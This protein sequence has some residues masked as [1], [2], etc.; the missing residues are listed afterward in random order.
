[1]RYTTQMSELRLDGEWDST[2]QYGDGLS[3]NHVMVFE[4]DS[5]IGQSLPQEDGSEINMALRHNPETN[6]L[7]GF[8]REETSPTG[9]YKGKVFEG[10]VHFILNKEITRAEGKWTGHNSD[11]TAVNTGI[12]LLAKRT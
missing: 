2:Y 1:M 12:W 5:L 11:V 3:S 9:P 4:Y 10:T 6:T 7:S 8:W